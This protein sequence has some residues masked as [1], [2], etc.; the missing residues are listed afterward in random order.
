MITHSIFSLLRF[1]EVKVPMF[2]PNV[3]ADSRLVFPF[4]AGSSP[5][6]SARDLATLRLYLSDLLAA[7]R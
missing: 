3:K 7:P 6:E 4:R 1:V 5:G 2:V